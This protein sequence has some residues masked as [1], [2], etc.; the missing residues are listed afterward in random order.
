MDKL[1]LAILYLT[2]LVLAAD[3]AAIAT[4]TFP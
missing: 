2:V 3:F 1:G 4:V